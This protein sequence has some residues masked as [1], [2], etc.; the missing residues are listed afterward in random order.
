VTPDPRSRHLSCDALR[1]HLD[2]RLPMLIPIEGDPPLFW[3]LE[4]GGRR[5]TLRIAVERG[6]RAPRLGAHHIRAVSVL[7]GDQQYLDIFSEQP[8]WL[9]E[10]HIV[11]CEIADRVQ[12]D[13]VP[14]GV[15]VLA[16]VTAW[17]RLLARKQHM[18]LEDEVGLFG[19]MLTLI[20]LAGTIGWAA[21]VTA[22]QH[23][24]CT[25]HDFTVGPYDVEVKTAGGQ[26]RIHTIH[27]LTQLM[28]HADRPLWFVSHLVDVSDV[29]RSVFSL[30]TG[31]RA[32]VREHAPHM[33]NDFE[34]RL[35]LRVGDKH[36]L[37]RDRMWVAQGAPLTVPVDSAFPRLTE[38]VLASLPQAATARI[39]TVKYRIDVADLLPA[40]APDN[41]GS[42][43]DLRRVLPPE[44]APG[45]GAEANDPK[46]A[47]R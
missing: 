15:A 19:E 5:P 25:E 2:N 45:L 29:G 28:P 40:T 14:P 31:V 47:L 46:D 16:T 10:F 42:A 35:W 36:E 24:E 17:R 33:L 18:T 1:D 9:R 21:A 43:V 27:G 37:P 6:S 3:H 20:G 8:A 12:E 13:R 7:D 32:L 34:A 23:P 38:G 22:W 4:A 30:V 41:L 44:L 39:L 11:C 26:S